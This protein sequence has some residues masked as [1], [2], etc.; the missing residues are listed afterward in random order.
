MLHSSVRFLDAQIRALQ[1]QRFEIAVKS[2]DLKSQGA[3]EIATTI[4]SKSLESLV[5]IATE[6]AVIRNRCNLKSLAG[7]I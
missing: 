6:I 2:P 4:A 5:E 1:W 3:S 7:W